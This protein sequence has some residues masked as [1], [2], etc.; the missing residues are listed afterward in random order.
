MNNFTWPILPDE[1]DDSDEVLPLYVFVIVSVLSGVMIL[2]TVVGNLLV[3][4]IFYR[5]KNVR[6]FSNY[7]LF[8]LA[9]T[10]LLVGL[11][12]IAPYSPYV[13]TGKWE[14]GTV[15]CYFWLIVDFWATAAS[16]VNIAVISFDR[17]LHVAYPL[18]YRSRQSLRLTIGMMVF[19]WCMGFAAFVPAILL[20]DV[21]RNESSIE[22]EDCYV[23]FINNLPYLLYGS[24]MEFIFPFFCVVVINI[25]IFVNIRK[26][27]KLFETQPTQIV[28]RSSKTP[29]IMTL[30]SLS[31]STS[32]NYTI[33]RKVRGNI[34]RDRKAAKALFILVFVFGVCWMPYEIST[35]IEPIAPGI[36][37][38][39]VLEVANWMLWLNSTINPFLYPLLH[40]RF[41]R[42]L[43]NLFRRRPRII[44]PA[45]SI[46]SIA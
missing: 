9:I 7:F 18:Y 19:P 11:V 42:A 36:V 41:R 30:A 31:S 46:M 15:F 27:Y 6:T 25:L 1:D 17:Y 5:D 29:S 23:P 3:V 14:M 21:G 33:T 35:L 20:W 10:D 12:S 44:E 22:H 38:E 28:A 2:L 45:S 34:L 16:S 37:N 40:R 26:R 43:S 4:I 13:L 8:N 32:A 24:C 39:H